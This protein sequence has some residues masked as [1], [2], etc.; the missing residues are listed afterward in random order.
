MPFVNDF[1]DGSGLEIYDAYDAAG[2][3]EAFPYPPVMLCVMSAGAALA[4]WIRWAGAAAPALNRFLFKLPLLAFDIVLLRTLLKMVSGDKRKYV[5]VLYAASPI[6]IYSAYMHGQLD[7]IPTGLLLSSIYCQ[8]RSTRLSSRIRAAVFLSLAITA[9]THIVVYV[10]LLLCYLY[11][12]FGLKEAVLSFLSV[13][14]LCGLITV[15]FAGPGL[16]QMVLFNKAQRSLIDIV[17][18]RQMQ[19]NLSLLAVAAIYVYYWWRAGSHKDVFIVF[20]GLL[21]AVFLI[22]TAPMPGWYVWIIPFTAVFTAYSDKGHMKPVMVYIAFNLAVVFYFAL[23]FDSG[24]A[25]L[26][27]M[28]ADVPRITGV[29]LQTAAF[30][31]M[32]CLLLI[33]SVVMYAQGVGTNSFLLNRRESSVITVGGDSGS[34]KSTMM[35]MLREML[36]SKHVLIIEGDGDHKYE[37]GAAEWEVYTH[38]NPKANWIYRQALDVERL[39]NGQ[40]VKRVDYDHTAGKFT[41]EYLVKPKKYIICGGLHT[42]YL[43]QM[44]RLSDLKIYLD[45]D[46]AL[47]EFWKI[48]RDTDSRGYSAEKILRQISSRQNDVRMYIEPQKQ[49]ADL[50]VRYFDPDLPEAFDGNYRPRLSVSLTFSIEIEAGALVDFL[51]KYVQVTHALSADMFSQTVTV[52]TTADGEKQA[53]FADITAVL[54]PYWDE[55]AAEPVGT[56]TAVAGAIKCAALMVLYHNLRTR[57]RGLAP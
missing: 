19:I 23:L 29:T 35:Q 18:S 45:T 1:L 39:K 13:S 36:G 40:S 31:M 15:P 48:Q 6:V 25:D 28:G 33:S 27:F 43:P 57:G 8:T 11:K 47:A 4:R 34:G 16:I 2:F 49:F 26:I 20:C 10:P 54:V 17:I 44:R 9:K 53:D 3:G 52:T 37:R 55:L 21:F 51:E 38:L 24:R 30:T 56:E 7:I 42:G 12:R 22:F 14:A 50:I 32:E 41:R 46:R 5:A